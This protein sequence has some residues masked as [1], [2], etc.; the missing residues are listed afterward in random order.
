MDALDPASRSLLAEG[1][2]LYVG[3]LTTTG[4]HV[5]PELYSADDRDIWFMT[6]ADTVKTRVIRRDPRVSAV[7]RIGSRA[8]LLSGTVTDYDL[9]A[10][11]ALL[12]QSQHAVAALAALSSYAARNA[13]DLAAFARDL[14]LGRLP[15]RLPPRRVL[16]RLRPDD[17]ALLD[18]GADLAGDADCAVGV[19]TEDGAL[20]LPGRTDEAMSTA[21]VPLSPVQRADVPFDTKVRGCLV[22]DD[23]G[24]PGP[25]AKRGELIRGSVRLVAQGNT[26]RVDIEPERETVWTGA[27]TATTHV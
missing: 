8:L 20:V 18:D 6:A 11:R 23:Y 22:V 26:C 24:A 9:A 25:A 1:R 2:Q 15:S 12:R 19:E 27:D 5:T 3:V 10:P 4:P 21:T 7:L 17:S 14:A 16:M 13:A